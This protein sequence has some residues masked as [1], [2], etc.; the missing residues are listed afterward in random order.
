LV[1]EGYWFQE[2]I[3]Q[4][5]I[6]L[7]LATSSPQKQLLAT[8]RG[9]HAENYDKPPKKRHSICLGLLSFI[10]VWAIF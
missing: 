7:K 10:E 3:L 1:K 9:L 5:W 8:I 2:I 4:I 6:H